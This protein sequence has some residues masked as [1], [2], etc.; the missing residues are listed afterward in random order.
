MENNFLQ[1]HI[2][3]IYIAHIPHQDW[4]IL[5]PLEIDVNRWRHCRWFVPS[6]D[7]ASWCCS[8]FV[9]REAYLERQEKK[10]K[11]WLINDYVGRNWHW[12][13]R[14]S[15]SLSLAKKVIK[16]IHSLK[17][18]KKRSTKFNYL[19]SEFVRFETWWIHSHPKHICENHKW[20][21][22]ILN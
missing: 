17:R 5:N 9:Q 14:N 12:N 13:I 7:V 3:L 18:R 1:Q 16:S 10:R 11:H 4:Q 21:N 20:M 22:L 19:F 2:S 8:C 6:S 15:S